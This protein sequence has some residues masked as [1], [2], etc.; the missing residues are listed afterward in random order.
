VTVDG[1]RILG[2][3]KQAVVKQKKR[4]SIPDAWNK[5]LLLDKI[6]VH[7]IREFIHRNNYRTRTRTGTRTKASRG[8]AG[9]G[10]VMD[11]LER[12]SSEIIPVSSGSESS[13]VAAFKNRVVLGTGEYGT[14]YSYDDPGA[15]ARFALKAVHFNALSDPKKYENI[16]KE[17]EVQKL[18]G[19]EGIAPKIHATHYCMENGGV[20]VLIVMDLM[21]VGDIDKFSESRALTDEHGAAIVEKVKRMHAMGYAHNDLHSGNVFVTERGETGKFD[22][23]IGDF[24]FV[25]DLPSDEGEAD[26]LKCR[27]LEHIGQVVSF[28]N[29]DHL[30]AILYGMVM[31][32]TIAVSMDMRMTH[33]EGGS[34]CD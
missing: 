24:G 6:F 34:E 18:M 31:D 19:E 10:L 7:I 26:R 23:F 1:E 14:T 27:D 11:G 9:V 2:H 22:F 3:L 8:G 17:I 16:V 28:V 32:G 15:K 33:K 20:T 21:T 30:R 5:N 4:P 13:C 25:E 12:I 29:R